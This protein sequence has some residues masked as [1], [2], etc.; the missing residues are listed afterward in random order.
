MSVVRS[1][2]YPN[3][4]PKRRSSERHSSEASIIR[5]SVQSV[6]YPKASPKRRLSERQPEVSIIRTSVWSVDY[7][8]VVVRSDDYPNV[9]LPKLRLSERQS[10]EASIIRTSVTRVVQYMRQV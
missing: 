5:A 4:N 10:S 7:P 6:D 9:I 3:V 8:N 2:D 1:V